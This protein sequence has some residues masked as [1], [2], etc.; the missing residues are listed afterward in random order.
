MEI[1]YLIRMDFKTPI[2]S[3]DPN[4][5]QFQYL[6]PANGYRL[7]HKPKHMRFGWI[8]AK[9]AHKAMKEYI[10]KGASNNINYHDNYGFRIVKIIMKE[11]EVIGL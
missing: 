4:K 9:E 1:G 10:A 8:S 7:K 3:T 11:E 2:S 6:R 5:N